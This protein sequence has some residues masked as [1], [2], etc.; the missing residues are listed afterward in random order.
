MSNRNAT[1]SWSGYSHQGQVGLLI[2]LRTLQR[3]G[4]DL[5]THFVQFETHEDVAVYEE[6]VGG[7]RTYLTVHQVK[8][9]YSAANIY[10]ST[11]HGVLNGDFEPGNERYLH[12]AVGIG[13]WDTS[14][15]TNNN[16]V[17]RYAYT[18]TQ[19]HCGTTEIEE[20]IKTELSTILNASQPVIDEVYYRLS[21]EL[22]HRIRMEHQKVHKYLFDI[23][24]SLLEI[25][26]LIRSTETFTKK[27]IYDCRKLFYET[28]IY[29]IHNANLTQDRI[30]KIHD[31]IIRQINN[32]DD[33]NFLMFLQRMNLNETPENLK[34]TQIYYNKE[35]LK[36]VFFKMIIEI[37]DTDPVLIENIVKFNKDTEASKFTLTAI[38]AEEEEK[39]TV[40]EN[41]LTNLKS[42]NLLWENHSLINRNIEIELINRNP[43]IFM[44]ATPEQKD[45][46][47]DKFMFFANSKLVKREDALLKLNNGNNN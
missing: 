36:Q 9:Y 43:A 38:I 35:G 39:L 10:K 45:D 32:L 16:G 24:F 17:L 15:T 6:P 47:N 4:I 2:A 33:S 27:D 40:V 11:Y 19:N 41:I 12:T 3:N 31:N 21:F 8:A 44:V 34:K 46:D 26:Q 23:K 18:A 14:A 37:I 25:D 1:A 13:D 7:P 28:Y 42:Q 20:F 29:V 30:D 22:D 5:N